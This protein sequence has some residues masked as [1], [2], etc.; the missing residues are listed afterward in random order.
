MGSKVILDE[1]KI[2][3]GVRLLVHLPKQDLTLIVLKG[4]ILVEEQLLS[5]VCESV[6]FPDSIKKGN[7]RYFHLSAIAKALFYRSDEQWLWESVSRLNTLRNQLAHHLEPESLETC[8]KQF[9]GPTEKIQRRLNMAID[10]ELTARL[11]SALTVTYGA[12]MRFRK[13]C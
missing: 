10:T 13:G 3:A 7:F 5:A 4:H 2:K 6:P 8:V 1:W 11:E 9:L 12:L